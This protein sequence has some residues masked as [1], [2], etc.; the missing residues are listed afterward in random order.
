MYDVFHADH[1]HSRRRHRAPDPAADAG[2]RGDLQAGDQRRHPGRGRRATGSAVPH[3]RHGDGYPHRRPHQGAA[4]RRGAGGRAPDRRAEA[5]RVKVVDANILLHAV[6][7]SAADHAAAREWLDGALSGRAQ[8]GLAWLP[9]VAFLRLSTRPG[10]FVRPL[11]SEE[12]LDVVDAWTGA[13]STVLLQ[14]GPRHTQ[15]LRELLAATG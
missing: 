9:L 3:A 11:T 15:I 14:P 8:V 2:H 12:A 7:S 13:P 4:T 10:L 6:N 1:C 5:R